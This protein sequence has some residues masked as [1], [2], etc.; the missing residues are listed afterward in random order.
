[1]A[2]GNEPQVIQPAAPPSPPSYSAQIQDYVANYPKL[3]ELQSTYD[4]QQ[5]QL[6]YELFSQ[7]APQYT[8]KAKELQDNLY[9]QTSQIQENLATQANQGINEPLPEWAKQQYMSDFNAGIGMNAN[10]PI[11]VSDRNVGLLSLQ[12]QWQDYYRNLGLSLAQRQPLQSVANP[13][14]GSSKE[15]LQGAVNYGQ[16]TYANQLSGYNTQVSNTIVRQPSNP[17]SSVAM[18]AA[19]G[20]PIPYV[21]VG[22]GA[23]LG[24]LGAF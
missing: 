11:G 3:M 2:K 14:F 17:W 7:Y 15:G 8:Q 4:P 23:I 10:A 1:M 18:G 9:P 21:G 24:A 16:N 13:S 5:A 20:A 19:M 6:Q 12:K 22:G